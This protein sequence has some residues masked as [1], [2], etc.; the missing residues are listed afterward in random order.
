MADDELLTTA[1]VA[2]IV[3]RSVATINRWAAEGKVAVVQKLP[4]ATGAHLF[5]REAVEHLIDAE[6]KSA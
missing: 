6:A 2:Q 4:G 3:G 1:E 5:R